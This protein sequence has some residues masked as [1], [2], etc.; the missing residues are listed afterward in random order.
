MSKYINLI[1]FGLVLNFALQSPVFADVII[2]KPAP[3]FTLTDTNGQNRSLSEFKGKYVVLEWFNFDCPFVQK[4]Y[5][6]GHMQG[7]QKTYTAKDVVWLSINSSSPGKEGNYSA[8]K[9][10]EM[11]QEK[12]ALPT[13]V[14][15]D[16]DGKVGKL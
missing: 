8:E 16:G 1:L 2:G 4:H 5:N 9:F 10:N 13:A 11:T 7:L 12:G 3:D 15:L 6:S 14:L